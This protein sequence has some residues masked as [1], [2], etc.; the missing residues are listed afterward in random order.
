MHSRRV[1][2]TGKPGPPGP[3]HD[4]QISE[5]GVGG[6]RQCKF[7]DL[8]SANRR[9]LLRHYGR[10]HA[11]ELPVQC[12]AEDCD[13]GFW[14]LNGRQ[15]HMGSQHPDEFEPVGTRPEVRREYNLRRKYGIGSGDYRVLL[16][17]QGGT[18]ATCDAT[19][20]DELN[21]RLHVDHCHETGRIRGLLCGECNLILGKASDSPAV[22][23]RLADYVESR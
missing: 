15:V 23:R 13:R 12:E 11:E 6:D 9:A 20:A 22:L 10:M 7:C 19:E 3:I 2:K 5:I 17:Q 18:C 4:F 8:E 1:A 14:T 21:R 16:E